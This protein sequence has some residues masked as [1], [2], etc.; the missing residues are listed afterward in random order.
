MP[1]LVRRRL[2][3]GGIAAAAAGV[4]TLWRGRGLGTVEVPYGS[5][6]R[7]VMDVTRPTGAGPF[8][9]LVMIH[10]GGFRSGDKAELPILP[11]FLAAGIA[12]VRV[13]YRFSDTDLWPAQAEDCQAA[14]LHLQRHGAGLGLDASRLVLFGRSAGAF[15]AVTSALRLVE[16]GLPP[17]GIVS[18]Y[19]AMDFSTMDQDMATL[20]LTPI[21][22]ETDAD[23]S[24]ESLV[25]GYAIG[26][27][28]AAARAMGPIARLEK[29]RTALPPILI[30]HGDADARIAH[31]QSARL[32]DA[33]RAADPKALVD[34]ALVPGAGHGGK[35]FWT[36]PVRA[37][38]TGFVIRALG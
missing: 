28:R 18:F 35:P 2:L 31:L 34:F 23:D 16:A 12:V 8:P 4:A 30:R 22:G 9:V 32:R 15:L 11:E 19:G 26:S 13:T 24:S 38:M 14:I 20:G 37:D 17:K 27:D 6:P 36:K 5:A 1:G 3:L 21:R 29:L 25:L 33:W 10:G 7:Q